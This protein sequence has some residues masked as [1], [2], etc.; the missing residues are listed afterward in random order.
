MKRITVRLSDA[1]A[2]AVGVHGGTVADPDAARGIRLL[3]VSGLGVGEAER[4]RGL[5]GAD[6]ETRSR[7]GSS[8]AAARW[9]KRKRAKRRAKPSM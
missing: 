4:P 5:L 8:G 7:V 9:P 1:Q 2:T 6:E 3:I